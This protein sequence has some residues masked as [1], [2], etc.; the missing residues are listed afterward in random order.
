MARDGDVSGVPDELAEGGMP[1]ATAA[2]LI[3]GLASR[4]ISAVGSAISGLVAGAGRAISGAARAL[5]K[6]R[7]GGAAQPADAN[8]VVAQLSSGESLDGSAKSQMESAFGSDFS[9]VRVHT[10][11]KAQELTGNMN[12]RAVTVGRDI[13]F[14]RGEY[15]P[16]TVVG[17]A[18]LAHEL[19]HVVQQG[20]GEAPAGEVQAKSSSSYGAFEE[21]A[22][23]AA[24][25]AVVSLVGGIPAS[26]ARAL[27]RD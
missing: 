10:D 17:D 27:F 5:F 25:G 9:R 4:A 18:L 21:D 24:A 1:G 13:A 14:A 11:S 22:D 19:A 2:G 16:G 23:Q 3:G 12:A 6:E 26:G 7:P 20:G 8:E 15:S